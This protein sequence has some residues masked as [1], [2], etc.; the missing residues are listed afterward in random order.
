MIAVCASV[1][2]PAKRQAAE[3]QEW[4]DGGVALWRSLGVPAR[5]GRC[6][7]QL[8]HVLLYDRPG[9]P[10]SVGNLNPL[11]TGSAAHHCRCHRC[12]RGVAY[13]DSHRPAGERRRVVP[14]PDEPV[15]VGADETCD[16]G[17]VGYR[18]TD[19]LPAGVVVGEVDPD[20]GRVGAYRERDRARRDKLGDR[21]G[22]GLGAD[23]E[24]AAARASGTEQGARYG[25]AGLPQGASQ[26]RQRLRGTGSDHSAYGTSSRQPAA[27]YTERGGR[28]P[29]R[30]RPPAGNLPRA[31][32]PLGTA[33]RRA[34]QG[35]GPPVPAA[36][37]T[38]LI[39]AR[40]MSST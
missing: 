27:T 29:R 3:E 6:P 33:G 24:A 23:D 32:F 21:V 9:N 2:C 11:F 16:D 13:G 30:S 20:G 34:G 40:R 15:A 12:G 22:G 18:A 7:R 17:C 28:S 19:R 25:P 35:L 36:S 31:P 14:R 26:S 38:A 5:H 8:R 1:V 10:P 39:H 37:C 4:L